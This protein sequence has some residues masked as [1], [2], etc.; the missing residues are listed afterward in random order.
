MLTLGLLEGRL[1]GIKSWRFPLIMRMMMFMIRDEAVDA[2]QMRNRVPRKWR[3]VCF[4]DGRLDMIYDMTIM[5]GRARPVKI[6]FRL[7]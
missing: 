2:C 7:E 4:L 5:K 3:G 6:R 1:A